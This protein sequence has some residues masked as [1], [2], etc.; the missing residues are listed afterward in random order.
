MRR[1]ECT[2]QSL[3]NIWL[4]HCLKKLRV[5][6]HV[7][8]RFHLP[9]GAEVSQNAVSSSLVTS[10]S[11]L[12][13]RSNFRAKFQA[14][15]RSVHW[16]TNIKTCWLRSKDHLTLSISISKLYRQ[17]LIMWKITLTPRRKSLRGG[18]S[19]ED[20]RSKLGQEIR[21]TDWSFITIHCLST[22][23]WDSS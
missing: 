22:K 12:L 14:V 8:L 2:S 9:I 11:A 15:D 16:R 3:Q 23:C 10:F 4:Q 17:N 5:G 13:W 7:C 6:W 1:K 21:Y 20:S 18:S 19:P